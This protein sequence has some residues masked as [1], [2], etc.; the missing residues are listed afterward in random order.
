MPSR[1]TLPVGLGGLMDMEEASGDLRESRSDGGRKG[2]WE[3]QQG[4]I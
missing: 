3:Q 1:Q 4:C 2:L